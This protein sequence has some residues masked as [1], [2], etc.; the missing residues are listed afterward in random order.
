M[1]EYSAS[2]SKYG[3]EG[4]HKYR[5]FYSYI[6]PVDGKKHRTSKRG[7]KLEKDA[8]KWIK[9]DMP[10]IIKQL[11]HVDTFDENLTMDELIEEYLDYAECNRKVEETTMGTK[12]S[13]INTH[14]LPYFKD[15]D[16][17]SIKPKD[18]LKWQQQ[19]MKFKK[20]N[21]EPYSETYLRTVENQLSAIFNYAVKYCDLS[22]NPIAERMGSKDAPEVEKWTV[23]MYREFQKHIED[24]PVFYYAFEVFFWCGVR[25]GE[26]LAITP[27]DIDFENKTLNIDKSMRLKNGEL[28]VG[29]T[30][31][32]SSKRK[33]CLPDI[34]VDELREYLDS[35]G[36]YASH[37]RIF[38]LSKTNL[39]T[40]IDKYSVE[41]KV[42]RITI[43][44][45]RH[46]HASLLETLGVPR[47]SI[48]RRLGHKIK[49]SKDVT[50]TYANP[51]E[52]TNEMVARLVNE[53]AIGK[54]NPSNLFESLLK[55]N[56]IGVNTVV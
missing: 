26:L 19:M 38:Q 31:T 49:E 50:T 29:P 10:N 6:S 13:C 32:P 46:S 27:R 4:N 20:A 33:I 47:T 18:I 23:D 44:A 52:C 21:G 42:P 9:Y 48:K 5:V 7:F 40:I 30:K 34:L 41:A 8:K 17:F 3:P 25:L 53:V 56:G 22:E 15:A 28:V 54:I 39:H 24:K 55:S 35:I 36:V 45:L 11:E 12:L 16:I 37:T 14:I 51:Y 43:H 1:S 2:I